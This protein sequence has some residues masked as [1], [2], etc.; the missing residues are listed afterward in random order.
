MALVPSRAARDAK[1][2]L[3]VSLIRN[4]VL[5]ATVTSLVFQSN[6]VPQGSAYALHTYRTQSV[7]VPLGGANDWVVALSATS[8]VSACRSPLA[9]RD[10]PEVR[11]DDEEDEAEPFT[12]DEYEHSLVMA[13]EGVRPAFERPKFGRTATD[14]V[15]RYRAALRAADTSDAHHDDCVRVFESVTEQLVV[16]VSVV[17][18]TSFLIE[19]HLGPAA[20]SA[21]LGSL[22]PAGLAVEQLDAADLVRMAELP[23]QYADLPLG[24]VDASVVAVAERLGVITL[25]TIDRRHFSVVRPRHADAFSLLP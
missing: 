9:M 18:E 14:S 16:P 13:L 4:D 21:F 19:R 20:E 5:A 12:L 17:I 8:P 11:S 6:I 25:L 24:A 22:V 7:D 2:V 23:A 1:R 10:E 3:A 15:V